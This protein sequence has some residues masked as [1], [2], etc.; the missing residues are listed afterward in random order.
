M[1]YL[2]LVSGLVREK[3][4]NNIGHHAQQKPSPFGHPSYIVAHC[5]QQ[6]AI[7]NST[8]LNLCKYLCQIK[9]M[10]L[11]LHSAE[12]YSPHKSQS[13]CGCFSAGKCSHF[14]FARPQKLHC[15]A[16]PGWIHHGQPS[17]MLSRD[18]SCQ[19]IMVHERI[20]VLGCCVPGSSFLMPV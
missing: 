3:S 12:A 13:S 1:L 20:I 18:G 5:V 15:L 8:P 6:L 19:A 2:A 9:I 4:N 16:D 17:C 7:Q 10:Q 11:I 14:L